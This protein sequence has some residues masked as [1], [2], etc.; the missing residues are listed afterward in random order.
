MKQYIVDAFTD[1]LFHGNQAAVCVLDE[2]LTEELMMNIAKENNFSE[3]AF[4][5]KNGDNYDLRWF[6]P[7]GEINLCGHATLAT[8]YVL[9]N[10]YEKDADELTF[11]TMSGDLFIHRQQDE[12]VMD[13]PAYKLNEVPVTEQMAKAMGA[14]PVK[15]YIDR[16]LLLVYED[17]KMIR[18]MKPDFEEVI[19]LEGEG[20]GVTAPGKEYDCVSRFFTPKDKINEDPV[21]GSAHCM[22]AP[23]W[24][25]RLGKKEIHAYQASERGG[26]LE[27]KVQGD[28]VVISGKAVLYS[29][30]ELFVN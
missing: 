24:A 8:S 19:L 26:S 5:V 11:H 21:T 3:T 29:V 17:E 23:Y 7:G 4:T 30:G 18:E 27:C 15:A 6:T 2:W 16:D 20:V 1:R 9:F 22:I 13:F 14:K 28:R 12:I 25:E 10:Y